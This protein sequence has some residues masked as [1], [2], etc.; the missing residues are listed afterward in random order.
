MA[1]PG[2][3]ASASA[4]RGGSYLPPA[5]RP[6]SESY[7]VDATSPRLSSSKLCPPKMLAAD[8]VVC[9][10]HSAA[11]HRPHCQPAHNGG[12]SPTKGTIR[13]R[14]QALKQQPCSA[15]APIPLSCMNT[16]FQSPTL[17]CLQ[18]FTH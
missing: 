17:F 5:L 3:A 2:S 12:A 18:H 13:A 4:K 16:C 15:V 8:P 11:G 14:A 10:D 7:H 9:Q 6:P 1:L